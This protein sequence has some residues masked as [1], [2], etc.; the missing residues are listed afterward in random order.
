MSERKTYGSVIVAAIVAVIFLAVMPKLFESVLSPIEA[1]AFEPRY[2]PTLSMLYKAVRS[3]YLILR[4]LL[5]TEGGL[6][7]LLAI[8]LVI[9][10]FEEVRR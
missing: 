4:G 9:M 6:V 8:A 3:I 2:S 10:V 1:F 7:L 5:T